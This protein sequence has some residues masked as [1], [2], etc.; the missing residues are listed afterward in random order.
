MSS[1]NINRPK[2]WGLLENTQ[3]QYMFRLSPTFDSAVTGFQ[4]EPSTSVGAQTS[5]HHGQHVEGVDQKFAS[6]Q[7]PD[8]TRNPRTPPT[9][10]SANPVPAVTTSR[11]NVENFEDID[12]YL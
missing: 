1:N 8:N 11:G 3:L 7:Q 2:K 9:L 12:S 5:T 4:R 10:P 6:R